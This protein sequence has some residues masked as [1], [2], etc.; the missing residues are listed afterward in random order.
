VGDRR[1]DFRT[2]GAFGIP[3]GPGQL[4]FRNSSGILARIVEGWQMSWILNL[5]SGDAANITAQN[6]LYGSGVPDRVGAFDPKA[7]DVQWKDGAVAG[8]YFGNTYHKVTDPQCSSITSTLQSFCTLSVIADGS[9]NIV[10]QNP[11]PGTRGNLG[12]RVIETPGRWNFDTAVSKS[13]KISETKRFQ[14]R[15]DATNIFNHPVPADPNLDINNADVPFGNIDTK[16]GQR[17]FQLQLRLE[18]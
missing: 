18:F 3:F 2:N 5:S 16:T 9:G 10:L 8:N 7:G 4:L 17:Q 14:L 11:K 1:H 12:Q 6:M 15:M 13:F